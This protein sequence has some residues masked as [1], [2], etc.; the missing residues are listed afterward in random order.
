MA[1][2]VIQKDGVNRL[3]QWPEGQV[4]VRESEA[5]L[6]DAYHIIEEVFKDAGSGF[7][8]NLWEILW[9]EKLIKPVDYLRPQ[10][11]KT[12]NRA[13]KRAV[14]KDALNIVKFIQEELDV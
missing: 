12:I 7:V 5:I 10:N 6:L 9:N 8:N 2:I 11:V 13:I 3:V 1:E 4:P 14:A